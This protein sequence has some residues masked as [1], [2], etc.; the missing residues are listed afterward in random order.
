RPL[1]VSLLIFTLT[2]CSCASDEPDTDRDLDATEHMNLSS[3]EKDSPSS[4]GDPEVTIAFYNVENLFDTEDDPATDEEEF[5]PRG[6]L[7]WTEERLEKKMEGLARAIRGIDR[8]NGP[9]II[10]FAEVENREVLERFAGD[11]F[12]GNPWRI[13]HEDSPDGRGIDVALFYRPEVARVTRH[14]LHP[15]NLGR[16]NR[17][18]RSI[19]NV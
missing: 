8:M 18:T 17:P 12:P 4:D 19:L 11:F 6:S 7:K 14:T 1:P 9:G 10:G 16:G 2:L 13:V 3:L 5:T 15:V